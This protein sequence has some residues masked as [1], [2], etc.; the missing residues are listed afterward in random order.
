MGKER[1]SIIHEM[2]CIK[3][4]GEMLAGCEVSV[5]VFWLWYC[6]GDPDDGSAKQLNAATKWNRGT[7]YCVNLHQSFFFTTSGKYDASLAM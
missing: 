2:V 3:I 5:A 7:W 4:L 1:I 6:V